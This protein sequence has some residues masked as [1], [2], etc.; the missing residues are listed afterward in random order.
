LHDAQERF[1]S[2]AGTA[3]AAFPFLQCSKADPEGGGELG[4]CQPGPLTHCANVFSF[5]CDVV[6]TPGKSPARNVLAD[7]RKAF[8]QPVEPLLLHRLFLASASALK[9]IAEIQS[10]ESRAA[11]F[12]T[13]GERNAPFAETSRTLDQVAAVGIGC[14]ACNNRVTLVS[15]QHGVDIFRERFR[16]SDG[17]Q[18][19]SW[20]HVGM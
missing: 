11:T 14:D 9:T 4:L 19:L 1:G 16:L 12:A 7:F 6:D 17:L 5:D 10:E 15:R 3:L 8:D 20:S 13:S 18:P 2:A